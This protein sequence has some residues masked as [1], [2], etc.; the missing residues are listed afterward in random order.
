MAPPKRRTP[1]TRARTERSGA[2]RSALIASLGGDVD[3]FQDLSDDFDD[4]A[5]EVLALSRPDLRCISLLL[6]GGPTPAEELEQALRLSSRETSAMLERLVVAGYARQVPSRGGERV[7]LTE[8]ARR[9][10]ETLWGPLAAE[11]GAILARESTADLKVLARF[12][13]AVL[14]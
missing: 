13:G 1:P 4:A 9:W 7:E 5:A 2:A 14:P 11:G 12:M 10:V 6:F 3:R 8:H